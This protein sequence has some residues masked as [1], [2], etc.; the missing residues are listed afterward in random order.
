MYDISNKWDNPK[1]GRH[2]CRNYNL[3]E[4]NTLIFTA[5]HTDDDPVD[6]ITHLIVH[7]Y[8]SM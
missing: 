3:L 6:N 7:A 8:K 2:S 1:A 5:M 4:Y